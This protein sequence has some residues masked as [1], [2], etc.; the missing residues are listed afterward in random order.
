MDCFIPGFPFRLH[1]QYIRGSGVV[2]IESEMFGWG[3]NVT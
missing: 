2:D 1:L 3:D